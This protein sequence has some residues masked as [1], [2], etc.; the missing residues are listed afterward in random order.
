MSQEPNAAAEI[1]GDPSEEQVLD[2][3]MDHPDFLVR[4]PDLLQVMTPP[5]RWSGDGVVDM[6]QFILRQLREDIGDLRECAQGV[7]ETSRNNLSVLTRTHA[8]V[9]ALLVADDFDQLL[10]VVGED[11]PLL[12]DV[13]VVTLGFEPPAFPSLSLVSP[14]VAA[15]PPG[16]VDALLGGEERDAALIREVADDGTLFGAASDLVRSAALARL[17]P[18]SQVPMGLLALGSRRAAAFHPGQGTE[19]LGFLAR[20]LERCVHACLETK[21]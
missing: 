18:G 20:I 10:R 12:L 16:A 11:L 13:D 4:H 1:D 3:L 8:A 2:Y 19:L 15:L 6:Q 5:G 7:I 14:E 17:Y 21:D 9:L